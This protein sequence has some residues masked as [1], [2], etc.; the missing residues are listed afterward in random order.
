MMGG[1]LRQVLS[2]QRGATALEFAILAPLLLAIV[3]GMVE[4]GLIFQADLAVTSAA[5]EGARLLAV[6][7]GAKWDAGVVEQAAYPLTAG[8]GLTIT[9]NT[10][11]SDFVV[12]TV[13]YPWTWRIL[14]LNNLNLGDPPVLV[15]RATMRKE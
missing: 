12:V 9:P 14:P 2:D 15:G 3:A 13:S 6:Q 1:R 4:F 11:S 10:A 7:D 5:R 8:D